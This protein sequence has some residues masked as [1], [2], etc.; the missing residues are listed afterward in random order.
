M[1]PPCGTEAA[2]RYTA[3]ATMGR[4]SADRIYEPALSALHHSSTMRRDLRGLDVQT[5][6]PAFAPSL[7]TRYRSGATSDQ[8]PWAVNGL[9]SAARLGCVASLGHAY[10]AAPVDIGVRRRSPTPSA[11]L[12]VSAGGDHRRRARGPSTSP[13]AYAPAA[14]RPGWERRSRWRTRW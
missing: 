2:L 14:G 8:A 3:F 4:P 6:R 13:C 9:Q 1:S 12:A 7:P 5:R 10:G 11:G